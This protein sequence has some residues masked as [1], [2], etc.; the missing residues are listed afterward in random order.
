VKTR[1]LSGFSSSEGG[2]RNVASKS[3]HSALGASFPQRILEFSSTLAR[4]CRLA[5]S[6]EQNVRLS[7]TRV[8]CSLRRILVQ[9]RKK[10]AVKYRILAENYM[11]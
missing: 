1:V 4:L 3:N 8:K 11:M 9:S 2:G 7:K 6:S 5:R 10:K